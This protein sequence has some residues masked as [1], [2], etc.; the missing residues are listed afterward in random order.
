MDLQGAGCA[1]GCMLIGCPQSLP[2]KEGVRMDEALDGKVEIRSG[3]FLYTQRSLPFCLAMLTPVAIHVSCTPPGDWQFIRACIFFLYDSQ[4]TAS[5]GQPG[6]SHCPH[7]MKSCTPFPASVSLLPFSRP[8]L[9]FKT[10]CHLYFLWK[11]Y[12]WLIFFFTPSKLQG[13]FQW[14]LNQN[15]YMLLWVTSYFYECSVRYPRIDAKGWISFMLPVCVKRAA[16]CM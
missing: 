9:S 11:L 8:A 2:W 7:S 3:W 12:S 15:L 13:K 6:S 16:S 14:L 5:K 4:V 1:A 10:T